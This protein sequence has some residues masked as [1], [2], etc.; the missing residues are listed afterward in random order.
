MEFSPETMYTL[1]GYLETEIYYKGQETQN[2]NSEFFESSN[3]GGNDNHLHEGKKQLDE[4]YS[5]L[6]LYVN[7]QLKAIEERLVSQLS[8]D[9]MEHEDRTLS[10]VRSEVT[11]QLKA[12]EERLVSQLSNDNKQHED[13]TLSVV[14]LE[15]GNQMKTIKESLDSQIQKQVQSAIKV[16]MEPVKHQDKQDKNSLETRGNQS[17]AQVFH[18]NL[19]NYNINSKEHLIYAVTQIHRQL[20]PDATKSDM[21]LLDHIAKWLLARTDRYK[22]LS[23]KTKSYLVNVLSAGVNYNLMWNIGVK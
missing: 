14:R 15:V 20:R 6:K 12:I 19:F 10:V 4:L 2:D 13:R 8:N 23:G 7:T 18:D 1:D 21:A 5:K 11:S 17:D 16:Q 22:F 9:K 3:R